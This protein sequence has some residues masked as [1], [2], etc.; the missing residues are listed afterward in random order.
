MNQPSATAELSKADHLEWE[1]I[2]EIAADLFDIWAGGGDLEWA[3]TAWRALAQAGMTAYTGEAERTICV[4]R[5]I[6]LA[7]VY[8]EFCV[9]AF[10][11]GSSGEWE[12][13][14]TSG[15][16]GGYPRLDDFTLG[17]LT[18]RRHLDVDSARLDESDPPVLSQ[19]ILELAKG[20]YRGVV[21][22]L[23]DQWGENAFFT[24]LYASAESGHDEDD[25]TEETEE[26]P[27]SSPVTADQINSVMNYD[28]N[29]GKG[30]AYAWF[31][32]GLPL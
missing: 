24:S 1:D 12:E 4:M 11:E 19:V 28:I 13:L 20:E 30:S 25:D 8:R 21:D 5:L 22:A 32:Q 9:R 2:E 14:V 7:A 23:T 17:Q 16:A 3:E 10:D 6:A 26:G 18:E 31:S 15:L 29:G 27:A